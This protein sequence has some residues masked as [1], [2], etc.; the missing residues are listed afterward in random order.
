MWAKCE[1]REKN[2]SKQEEERKKQQQ[3]QALRHQNKM[4]WGP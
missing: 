2:I 3:R 1:K 4:K